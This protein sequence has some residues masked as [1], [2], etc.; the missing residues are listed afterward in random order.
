MPAQPAAPPSTGRASNPKLAPPSQAEL[1]MLLKAQEGDD[2]RTMSGAGMTTG[3][4]GRAVASA[5]AAPL[6]TMPDS[7]DAV[8]ELPAGWLTPEGVLV[9]EARCRE[10]NG[11]DE[12]RL[13]RVDPFKNAALYLTELLT[14]GVEDLGGQKPTK[15]VL[16]SLLIGDRD[17]LM[18]GVRQAT[19]GN[20][21]EFKLS[22]TVC[23]NESL[24]QVQIDPDVSVI[25][26]ADPLVREFDVKLRKG[27]NARVRLLTGEAQEAYSGDIGKKTQAEITTVMLA[28]SVVAVNGKP[29]GGR[30]EDVQWLSAAD[31]QTISDFISEHQPGPQLNKEIPV[32]CATC[33]EEYPILLGI[34]NLFRF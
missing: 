2:P 29:V 11:Y 25:K 9:T 23:D 8:V 32:A 26:L 19:Y 5:S 1:D 21:V 20:D 18:L 34:P 12:E 13:S 10:L 16:R 30:T 24:I 15:D 14:L 17:A 28:K 3:E 4:V 33:G 22:C 7:T 31:R 6:P 27:G